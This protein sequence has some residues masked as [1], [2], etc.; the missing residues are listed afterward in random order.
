MLQYNFLS[1]LFSENLGNFALTKLLIG[2]LF[3]QTWW[4]G[5]LNWWER[6]PVFLYQVYN[7]V[8]NKSISCT[9]TSYIWP[10]MTV[11]KALLLFCLFESLAT[12]LDS[13]IHCWYVNVK[14]TQ[15]QTT[16]KWICLKFFSELSTS[17]LLLRIRILKD[18][19]KNK[20]NLNLYFL[21]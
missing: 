7:V 18:R 1:T 11:D 4:K 5:K 14:K 2:N 15:N 8:I 9:Y 21:K 6:L 12:H 17:Q 19:L 20:N 3:L 10:A 16:S 13:Q